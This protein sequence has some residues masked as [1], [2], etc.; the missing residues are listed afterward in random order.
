[1]TPNHPTAIATV[2]L[3]AGVYGIDPEVIWSRRRTPCVVEARHLSWWALRERTGW[4]Y[5]ELGRALGVDH[6][7][8]LQG[9]RRACGKVRDGT[10]SMFMRSALELLERLSKP[11]GKPVV[12]DGGK[13]EVCPPPLT[14]SP[15]ETNS[16]SLVLSASSPENSALSSSDQGPVSK[17]ARVRRKL[18][19]TA[20]PETLEATDS[21]RRLAAEKGIDLDAEIRRCLE[22]HRAR[23]NTMANW[24]AAVTTW[25]LSPYQKAVGNHQGKPPPGANFN[26]LRDRAA[27]LELEEKRN[28]AQ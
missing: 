24:N 9:V 15:S 6:S 1:M 8:V 20:P 10:G 5:P 23:G 7:S 28:A 14:L 12:I 22:H 3:I 4:S 25:L 19:R 2:A 13:P 11:E 16:Q 17:R 21:H 18:P 27:Q 26:R